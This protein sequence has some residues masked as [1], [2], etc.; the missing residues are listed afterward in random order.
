MVFRKYD[1]FSKNQFKNRIQLHVKVI[2]TELDWILYSVYSIDTTSLVF[3]ISI[4]KL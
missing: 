3:K 4:Y 1:N 2:H